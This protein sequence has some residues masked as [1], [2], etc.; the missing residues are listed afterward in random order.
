[1]RLAMKPGVSLRVNH[2]LAELHVAEIADGRDRRRVGLRPGHDLQQPHIARRVEEM[3][4]QEIACV[5]ASGRP[6]VR[7]FSGIVEVFD[8]TIEPGLRTVAIFS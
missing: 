8:D 3:R 4:D 6:A 1:M 7:S 5:N 2:T